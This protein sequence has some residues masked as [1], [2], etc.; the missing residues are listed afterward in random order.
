M[1]EHRT[2]RDVELRAVALPDGSPGV[3]LQAVTPYVVDDY[4][5]V[6]MPGVFDRSLEQ[7]LP[8]LCWAHD[9]A[10]PIGPGVDWSRAGDAGPQVSFR[11]SDFEAVPQARRAHAQVSDGT[12]RD[13]SVGFSNVRRRPPTAGEEARWPGVVE[14]IEDADLDEVSLVLRGAVPGAKVL[15]VRTGQRAASVDLDAVVEVGRKVAAGDITH[16]E[17]KATLALLATDDDNAGDGSGDGSDGSDGTADEAAAVD[18]EVDAVL[19]SIGRSA[20]R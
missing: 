16:D 6:W 19:D 15:S 9:W 8:A 12:I 20:R 5:S 14:V 1:T 7:R 13:C 17:A 4:G 11:F 3:V 2:F 10:D 18:A